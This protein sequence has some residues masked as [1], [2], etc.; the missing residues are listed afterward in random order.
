MDL[1]NVLVT[2]F[3]DGDTIAPYVSS[4]EGVVDASAS[5]AALSSSITGVSPN[6]LI[7]HFSEA[8]QDT[9]SASDVTVLVGASGSQTAVTIDSV[10]LSNNAD[11]DI[12]LVSPLPSG[13]DV[14]IVINR[15]NAVDLAGNVVAT[16]SSIAYDGYSGSGNAYLEL[17]LVTASSVDVTSPTVT[18]VDGVSDN[19][20]NPGELAGEITGTG[21][22][23]LTVIMS[24][25]LAAGP[26]TGDVSVLVGTAPDQEAVS[27][28][29]VELVDGNRIAIT[30]ASDLPL[31]SDVEIEMPREALADTAGNEVALNADV[32]YDA[33][34][35]DDDETLSL[36]LHTAANADTT[37]P[38]ISGVEGV[39][40][41]SASRG[42]LSPD[43]DGSLSSPLVIDFSEAVTGPFTTAN[44]EVLTGTAPNQV[45]H[46]ISSTTLSSDGESLS[47]ALASA[48]AGD[49]SVQVNLLNTSVTDEAGNAPA[50]NDDINYDAFTGDDNE[51]LTTFL[52]TTASGNDTTSPTVS[53]VDGVVDADVSPAVL[54]RSIDGLSDGELVVHFSEPMQTLLNSTNVMLYSVDSSGTSTALAL[55][56]VTMS[57]S[58][59][60]VV[61]TSSALSRGE[62]IRLDMTRSALLDSAG[63]DAAL[64]SA[65]AYD[66]FT[67]DAQE[68]LSLNFVTASLGA[69]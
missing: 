7:V 35:G 37:A 5:P 59:T 40:D 19:S 16:S 62:T 57:D 12:S 50:L 52:E 4:V 58:T 20:T 69:N 13:T 42:V 65:I 25:T 3:Q 24:E 63:N 56:S 21:S 30:L 61:Q 54:N 2:P 45:S 48:L 49:V 18:G 32:A 28:Q 31:D 11:L 60:L 36:F 43:V 51:K 27:V 15:A 14:D 6:E 1:A 8:M 17:S 55:A 47:I 34:T 64:S 23:P 53:S 38:M 66:S 41:P 10:A 33:F 9:L 26:T 44:V 29:S 68:Y 67:G 46:A 39:S 22:E